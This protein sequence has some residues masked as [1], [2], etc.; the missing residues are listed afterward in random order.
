MKFDPFE[1]RLSRDIRNT[2]GHCFVKAIQ[3]KDQSLFHTESSQYQS[4]KTQAHI[5]TYINN[6]TTLLKKVFDQMTACN[7]Q[8]DNDFFLIACILWNFELFFEF[9]EWL[10]IKWT[11]ARG[12]YKKALQAMILAAIAYEQVAYDRKFSAKK[13][14]LKAIGLFNQYKDLI[15]KPFDANLFI[16]KLAALDPVAPKFRIPGKNCR[17]FR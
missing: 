1:N 11:A 5:K 9:H 7:L 12:N 4:G 13:V 8:P 3:A 16:V 14:A 17:A 6:R 10:E 15:P 2:L